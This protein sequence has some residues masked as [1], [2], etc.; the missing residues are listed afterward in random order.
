MA[1][2]RVW[3]VVPIKSFADAKSRLAPV[4]GQALRRGLASLMAERVLKATLAS[5]EIAQ[6]LVVTADPDAQRLAA[7]LGAVCCLM[8]GDHG[9][10]AAVEA[11]FREARQHCETVL[12]LPSDV[13]LAGPEDLARLLSPRGRE[14]TVRIVAD[15]AGRGTN[16]LSIPSAADFAFRFG[17]D[18]ASAHAESAGMAGLRAE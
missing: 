1:K 17:T 2:D 12:I 11:G 10:N 18:S 15:K 13:P 6:T 14:T 4:L 16:A 8:D 9:V 7:S 5:P 3:A